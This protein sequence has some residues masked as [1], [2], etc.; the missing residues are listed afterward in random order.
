MTSLAQQFRHSGI[1]FSSDDTTRGWGIGQVRRVGAPGRKTGIRLLPAHVQ[2]GTHAPRYKLYRDGHQTVTI[3]DEIE[4][5]VVMTRVGID[6]A[7]ELLK[8]E[9]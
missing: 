7:L 2:K 6:D 5:E 8:E 9:R 4:Q 3:V 1:L